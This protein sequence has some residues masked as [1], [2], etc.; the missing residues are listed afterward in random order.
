MD[1]S[2]KQLNS[3]VRDIQKQI[4]CTAAA[5]YVIQDECVVNEWYSGRHSESDFSRKVDA[6]SQFNVASVR[7]TYLAFAISLLIEKGM[8]QGVDDEISDYLYGPSETVTGVTIRHCLTH[9]H[10]LESYEGKLIQAFLPGMDWA[11]NNVGIALLT[12]MVQNVTG[13]SLTELMFSEVFEPMRLEETGWRTKY[14]EP[15]I[16]NYYDDKNNWVGPNDSPA[17]DQSNLFVSARDLAAWGNLHLNQGEV[18]GKQVFSKSIFDRITSLQT[19][20]A[21]PSHLPRQGFIWWLQSETP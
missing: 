14:Q 5:V 19:P 16:Y 8:I 21:L 20:A 3:Y 15:L 18:H 10:G 7:K 12:E 17:G 4:Q 9:T 11:Y 6:E 1:K 13:K 2:F